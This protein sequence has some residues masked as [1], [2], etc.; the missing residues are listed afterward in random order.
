MKLDEIKSKIDSLKNDNIKLE[1]EKK[2]LDS[3]RPKKI[4]VFP[5]N[6]TKQGINLI[7]NYGESFEAL[8]ILERGASTQKVKRIYRYENYEKQ[9][10]DKVQ[11]KKEK[12]EVDEKKKTIDKQISLNDKEIEKLQE[13]EKI[14]LALSDSSIIQKFNIKAEKSSGKSKDEL[15]LIKNLFDIVIRENFSKYSLRIL[16]K[17]LSKTESAYDYTSLGKLFK[18]PYFRGVIY[19]S[20]ERRKQLERKP[21]SKQKLDSFEKWIRD[22]WESQKEIHKPTGKRDFTKI[23]GDRKRGKTG[24]FD[25]QDQ[26]GIYEKYEEGMSEEDSTEN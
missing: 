3:K 13:V 11:F 19:M 21:I 15:I 20:I 25:H 12:T 6:K 18:K 26:Q 16:E 17:L 24:T 1:K 10:I 22:N 4:L 23:P 5:K 14:A 7:T 2:Y 9:K 8:S